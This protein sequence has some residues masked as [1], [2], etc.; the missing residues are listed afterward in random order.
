MPQETAEYKEKMGKRVC[1]RAN[2]LQI[3]AFLQYL[4]IVSLWGEL[5]TSSRFKSLFYKMEQ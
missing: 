2:E 1:T 4:F 3:P 5:Q